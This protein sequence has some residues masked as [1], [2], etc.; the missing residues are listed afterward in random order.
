MNENLRLVF[1]LKRIE[2]ARERVQHL[3]LLEEG[4]RRDLDSRES[5]PE[6][7]LAKSLFE[8]RVRVE[9]PCGLVLRAS[10]GKWWIG[11]DEKEVVKAIARDNDLPSLS[12]RAV[13]HLVNL[14]LEE[15]LVSTSDVP[16]REVISNLEWSPEE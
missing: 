9:R 5:D 7:A 10:T 2:A 6:F 14:T 15:R 11:A 3:E 1:L 16:E 12:E 4:L 13:Y 8:R